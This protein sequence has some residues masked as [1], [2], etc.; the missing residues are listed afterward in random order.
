MGLP[1][2]VLIRFPEVI[3]APWV[4]LYCLRMGAATAPAPIA[5]MVACVTFTIDRAPADLIPMA[6]GA[7]R[8]ATIVVRC[9]PRPAATTLRSGFATRLTARVMLLNRPN[10]APSTAKQAHPV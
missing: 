1:T 7:T 8:A 2:T 4:R 9:P 5:P 6:F 3:F 10:A